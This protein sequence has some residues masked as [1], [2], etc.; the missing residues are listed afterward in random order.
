MIQYLEHNK[1]NKQNWDAC[2]DASVN[3]C[4]FVYS[5]YLDAVC[6]KWSAFILNDYEAVFPVA[7]KS[8]YAVKYLYQPFFTRYFG[9]FS[10]NKLSQK[11]QLEFMQ[12]I[13]TQYRFIDFCLHELHKN[14][15]EIFLV[16]EKKYQ[17]IDLSV[18][19]KFLQ[20]GYSTNALRNIK[21]AQKLKLN[22]SNKISPKEIVDLFRKSKGEELAVFKPKDYTVLIKLMEQSIKQKKGIGYSVLNEKDQVLAGAFFIHTGN[23]L[24][25]L[26][27]GVTDEGKEKGAMHF[28]FDY[29]INKYAGKN[30]VLDFGGSTVDSVARFYKNFGAKD[31][32][33]LHVKQNKLP[34]LLKLIKK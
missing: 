9:V 3:S 31:C 25:F 6:E 32:V 18:E 7:I 12:I 26:K 4:A 8:K 23:R 20:K 29:I 16:K 28:L 2:I 34:K 27:S 13:S 22:I 33:Y 5:W 15:S 24:L 21:K 11:T 14:V 19:Y 17:F 10:K 1:I 30:V